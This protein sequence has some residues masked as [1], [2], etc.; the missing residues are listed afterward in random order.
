ME[1]IDADIDTPDNFTHSYFYAHPAVL[2]DLILLMR[3]GR[4]AGAEHGRPLVRHP[5][6]FWVL[7]KGYPYQVGDT[8]K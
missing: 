1:F 2:S 7:S 5:S 8:P 3:D 4:A 6:G